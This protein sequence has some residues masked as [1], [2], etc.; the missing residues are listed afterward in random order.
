MNLPAY[1]LSRRYTDHERW[2]CLRTITNLARRLDR[3]FDL[4]EIGI[5]FPYHD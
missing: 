1:H 4:R 3:R 2:D 5:Y